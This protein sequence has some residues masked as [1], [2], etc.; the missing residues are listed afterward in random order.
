MFCRREGA[1]PPS[2][3]VG[4]QRAWCIGRFCSQRRCR[5]RRC[6]ANSRM[7]ARSGMHA[8]LAR[9]IPSRLG[10]DTRV[11]THLARVAREG[12]ACWRMHEHSRVDGCF[13]RVSA[14]RR[15]RECRRRSARIPA[16][17]HEALT[18]RAR[19]DVERGGAARRG[20]PK[21]RGGGGATII[22]VGARQGGRGQRRSCSVR[23]RTTG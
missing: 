9:R 20:R 13:P 5:L 7:R 6:E 23:W 22:T 3:R 21:P 12:G 17:V 1:S 19:A 2:P 10:A 11:R 16:A 15:C 14:R 8:K 4:G 18:A